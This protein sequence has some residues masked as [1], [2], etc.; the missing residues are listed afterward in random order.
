[1]LQI[2]RAKNIAEQ[3]IQ[4]DLSK[5]KFKIPGIQINF[6]I[7]NG[8]FRILSDIT[9]II[10]KASKHLTPGGLKGFTVIPHQQNEEKRIY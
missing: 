1:M 5:A 3:L 9:H 10:R 6:I 7:S 8:V 4:T 2:C